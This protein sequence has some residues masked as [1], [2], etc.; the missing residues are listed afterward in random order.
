MET[1]SADQS[2]TTKQTEPS[3]ASPTPSR[4]SFYLFFCMASQIYTFA[5]FLRSAIAPITDVLE[6]EFDATTSQIGLCSSFIFIGYCAVQIP[7]GMALHVYSPEFVS[8]SC[9]VLMGLCSILFGLST[10][11]EMA[12]ATQLLSGIAQSATAI[13]V[14]S[15]IDKRLGPEMVPLCFGLTMFYCFVNLLLM[16]YLQA[17]IYETYSAW[18][19]PFY[20]T[21]G[22]CLLLAVASIVGLTIESKFK[23]R[24]L[25]H[26]N[27]TATVSAA[28]DIDASSGGIDGE[29]A[30]PSDLTSG[31]GTV[32]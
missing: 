31:T 24:D 8:L 11:I 29:T 28:V 6:E 13:S 3:D 16:Q 5:F 18:K 26:S 15:T 32:V 22:C 19:P 25:N 1:K 23:R 30:R 10:S 12:S 4:R 14:L 20:F 2:P 27:E 9:A 21:G 17:I 7:A